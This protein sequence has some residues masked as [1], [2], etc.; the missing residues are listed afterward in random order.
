VKELT[1]RN[2]LKIAAAMLILPTPPG[3]AAVA[4]R[5]APV[6]APYDYYDRGG[7]PHPNLDSK[8]QKLGLT[9]GEKADLLAFLQALSGRVVQLQMSNGGREL[10]VAQAGIPR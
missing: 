7:D 5:P 8:M 4:T 10:Q 9:A 2:R 3:A 1:G 6:P